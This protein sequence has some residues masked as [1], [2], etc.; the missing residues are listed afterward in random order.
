MPVG[1]DIMT[2]LWRG[3]VVLR[4]ITAAFAAGS[5]V[6][7]HGG[8]VRPALGWV[9]FAGILVWTVLTCLAYSHEPT[10]RV[11]VLMIDLL[12]TLIL[13]GSS[14]LV[15]SPS[16][17][18]E[19]AERTPLLTTVWA[20]GPVVAAAVHAGWPAG[21]LFG[22]AVAALDVWLRGAFSIDLARDTIL[23][24]GTGF[25]VGLAA[26][27]ARQASERLRRA[28]RAEAASAERERLARSIH[29]SVVQVLARV[30]AR[31]GELGGE[32]AEL[33]RLAGEQEI[34]LRSLFS[35]NA[36]GS[37]FPGGEEERE[38]TA[39]RDLTA[40]LQELA[41]TRVEVC[42]PAT[43]VP[44]PA[45]EVA[46]LVAV[47]REALTNTARHAGPQTRSWILVEDLGDQV[48]ITIRDDGP[49]IDKQS[50]ADAPGQ[51]RMGVARSIRG[52]VAELG[53][54]VT[55]HTSAGQGTQWQV[56][57]SRHR[58][59]ARQLKRAR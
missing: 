37:S 4:V 20:S 10:R 44:L 58:P 3:V 5:I 9:V 26:S 27:A 22:A 59:G 57:L 31:G 18:T 56:R 23:L 54:T 19:P 28:A 24:V 49:G 1:A 25:V 55:L 52:R 21:S 12:V 42:A 47:A 16:Q 51:G 53:G 7:H 8:Y 34:A 48:V 15:L 36:A 43:P 11:R 38:L 46:E 39:Q 29:D 17:L 2:P 35:A 32:A 13:M 30:R 50:L 14:A 40:A 41:G 33:A 6:L 45:A